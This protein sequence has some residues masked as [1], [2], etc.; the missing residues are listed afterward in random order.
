MV[1]PSPLKANLFAQEYQVT[2]II[3]FCIFIWRNLIDALAE[4]SITA[5]KDGISSIC[6]LRSN[7]IPILLSPC[8]Y[9]EFNYNLKRG[10]YNVIIILYLIRLRIQFKICKTIKIALTCFG[11]TISRTLGRRGY[12]HITPS[13]IFSILLPITV[14][15]AGWSFLLICWTIMYNYCT[16]EKTMDWSPTE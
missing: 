7:N 9:F 16:R 5:C 11:K 14:R 6:L 10:R 15:W 12:Q 13:K 8:R 2:N 4:S 1:S 3:S